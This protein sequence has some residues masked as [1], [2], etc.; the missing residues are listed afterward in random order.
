MSAAFGVR[1]RRSSG[2]GARRGRLFATLRC[3]MRLQFRNGFYYATAFVTAIYALALSQVSGGQIGLNIAALFPVFVLD[4]M[5]VGTFYFVAGQVLLEKGEETLQ[6]Q[7]VSPLR[8]W[9]YLA[10]KVVTLTLLTVV[11][12][13]VLL[14]VFQG[15]SLA[16]GTLFFIAGLALASTMYVLVGFI[17]VA[18]YTS[19]TDYLI[20]SILYT[21][22]MLLPLGLYVLSG[23]NGWGFLAY[24]AYLHPMEAPLQL[25]R[26]G[27]EEIA[28]WQVVYGLAYSVV[29]ICLL[30]R[31]S[32]RAFDKHIV[33]AAGSGK[34]KDAS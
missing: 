5:L 3:D 12:Y 18:R 27:F 26:A 22:F 7:V 10:S 19:V 11:Q 14:G 2:A 17:S 4:S 9:E 20:P 31:L 15:F 23:L 33:G 16:P 6:A 21:G 24:V 32:L 8:P 25:L 1:S 29:W 13:L 34:E 28:A 30:Y